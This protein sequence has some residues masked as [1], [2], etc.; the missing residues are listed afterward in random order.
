MK[1]TDLAA[2]QKTA[3][4]YET[5]D[6]TPERANEWLRLNR[7]NRQIRKSK[8]QHYAEI[9]LKN[10]WAQEHPD[11]IIFDTNGVMINGQHRLLAIVQSQ[12]TQRMRVLRNVPPEMAHVIDK[13]VVRDTADSVQIRLRDDSIPKAAVSMWRRVIAGMWLAQARDLPYYDHEVADLFKKYKDDIMTA[14]S[15]FK[16]TK[17]G[18]SRIGVK[19]AV[20][21][22]W[23]ALP[24]KHER[25]QEFVNVL[26]TGHYTTLEADVAAMALRDALL[27]GNN[28]GQK[29]D[30]EIFA[31]AENA[32]DY[33][34]KRKSIK[35][36]VPANQEKFP[37]DEDKYL[38]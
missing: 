22:A 18:I 19:A 23:I 6:V 26:Y 27:T 2:R 5:I 28:K 20:T 37:L 7:H 34:L 12:K 4:E 17:K 24:D 10:D 13:G 33:F 30:F 29:R 11:P 38:K 3:P 32:L 36:A 8:V 16:D 31:K 15:L 9:M 1:I 25:I 35:K 14:Y 21:R